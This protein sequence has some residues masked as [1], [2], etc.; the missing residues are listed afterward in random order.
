MNDADACRPILANTFTSEDIEVWL[1]CMNDN[2]H[3]YSPAE[4]IE[5]GEGDWAIEEAER[6]AGGSDV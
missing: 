4:A 5:A 6:L 1:E 2:L 3:G